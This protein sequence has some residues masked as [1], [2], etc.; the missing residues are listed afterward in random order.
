[1]CVGE[2]RLVTV[3]PHLGHGEKGGEA[4]T[5]SF[6]WENTGLHQTQTVQTIDKKLNFF[7][8]SK[9][10]IF[11]RCP[12]CFLSGS[13]WCA[14]QRRA[15]LWHRAD[16]L[17]EG[18]ATWLPVRVAP[19]E[20]CRPVR[21]SGRRQEPRGAAGGGRLMLTASPLALCHMADNGHWPGWYRY[22]GTRF[23][24]I[25]LFTPTIL[26]NGFKSKTVISKVT[27]K[28]HYTQKWSGVKTIF[29]LKRK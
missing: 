19:G 9:T 10:E 18:S 1:M 24:K 4:T 13:H 5:F 16:E 26:Q 7:T 20:S 6:S 25:L 14:E 28:L 12:F 15:D 29:P 21:S 3:P 2:R 17:R 23:G 11:K 22:S 8:D 27:I